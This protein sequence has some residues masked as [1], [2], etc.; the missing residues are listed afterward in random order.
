MLN[1]KMMHKD[2]SMKIIPDRVILSPSKEKAILGYTHR[3]EN[4]R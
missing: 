3:G 1:M 2:K 4:I